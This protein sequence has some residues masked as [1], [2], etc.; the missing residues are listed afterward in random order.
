MLKFAFIF[1]YYWI[2]GYGFDTRE[3]ET[4]REKRREEVGEKW[5]D[6]WTGRVRER[7]GDREYKERYKA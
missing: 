1:F 3:K 2:E 6:G 7:G 4:D 5:E